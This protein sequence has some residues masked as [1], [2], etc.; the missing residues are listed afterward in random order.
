M[1]R[2]ESCYCSFSD[3]DSGAEAQEIKAR[4]SNTIADAITKH[5]VFFFIVFSIPCLMVRVVDYSAAQPLSL[6]RLVAPLHGFD[7]PDVL[8]RKLRPVDRRCKAERRMGIF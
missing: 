6:T 3:F 1:S 8:R 7:F 5:S 4:L 2:T